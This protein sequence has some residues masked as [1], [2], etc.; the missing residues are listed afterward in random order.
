MEDESLE[1]EGALEVL[2]GGGGGGYGGGGES[3]GSGGAGAR[4][5]WRWL[6]GGERGPQLRELGLW[7]RSR[8]GGGCAAPGTTAAGGEGAN[9]SNSL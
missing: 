3:G 4:T 9:P 7:A 2:L 5:G 1:G 8:G 6:S